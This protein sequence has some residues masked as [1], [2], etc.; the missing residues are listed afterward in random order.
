MARTRTASVALFVVALLSM[1]PTGAAADSA[2]FDDP[3]DSNGALDIAKIGHTNDEDTATYRIEFHDQ[4]GLDDVDGL[5]WEFDFNG[6]GRPAEACALMRKIGTT[7]T[8][9]ASFFRDCGP[10]AWATADARIEERAIEFAL[11]LIDLV[12]GGGLRPGE[13]YS[14]RVVARDADG[15]E[16]TAPEQELAQHE[17]VPAPT[18]RPGSAETELGF[19]G[20]SGA[21][22][23]GN[24]AR[25][26]GSEDQLVPGEGE[27]PAPTEGRAKGVSFRFGPIPVCSGASCFAV[28]VGAPIAAF[29][30]YK[31]GSRIVRARRHED[32]PAAPLD[33]DEQAPADTR[34]RSHPGHSSFV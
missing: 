26:A 8:L 9:R 11:P 29:V 15:V 25:P 28:G 14:Y 33:N 16:D 18:A 6:D 10:E 34:P 2:S 4:F 5:A 13:T 7:G 31:L 23:A 19:P 32:P 22:G 27:G 20:E 12:E 30:L 24:A 1:L 17:D 21:A 3:K